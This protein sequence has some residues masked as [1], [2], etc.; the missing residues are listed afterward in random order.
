MPVYDEQ[1]VKVEVS[2]FNGVIKTN[3][4]DDKIPK[5]GM[6]YITLPV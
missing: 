3:F 1:Y 2:Q 5:E 4:L 6:H